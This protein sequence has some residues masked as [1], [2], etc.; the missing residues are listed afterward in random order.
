MKINEGVLQ[1]KKSDDQ[2]GPIS[3]EIFL[4]AIGVS[5]QTNDFKVV[6]PTTKE[7]HEFL[8]HIGYKGDF[9]AKEF[10]NTVPGIWTILIHMIVRGFSKKH[11]GTDTMRKGWL[12]VIY[13]I[14]IG[15]TNAIDLPEFLW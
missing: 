5:L 4:R 13:N 10:K 6:K 12:Y 7:F 9:K 11:G 2:F 3:K 1:C 15:W 14:F 8:G